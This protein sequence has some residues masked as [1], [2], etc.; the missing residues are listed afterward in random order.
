MKALIGITTNLEQRPGCRYHTLTERYVR[1][2]IR[3]GGLP[4]ILPSWSDP[5][6]PADYLD[7]IDGLLLTGGGDI[8]P[9]LY[10]E[11]PLAGLKSVSQ[12]R[13][14]AELALA[15]EALARG[16]PL[17]GVCRGHQ[18][19]NVAM[20]GSLYQDIATQL[21]GSSKH[22]AGEF[23]YEEPWHLIRLQGRGT[24]LF[25]IFGKESVGT[26]SFHHQAVKELAPG[27]RATATSADGVIEAMEAEEGSSFVLSVQFHP[28]GMIDGDPGFLGLFKAFVRA[29]SAG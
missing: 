18:V 23:P 16:M 6:S 13:D 19:L 1:S 5:S 27:L 10:G 20:G 25:E 2:V 21:P 24:R 12:R 29:A 3:A 8:A 26:N 28:E 14:Q 7:R 9:I 4:I 15:K 22:D 17:F 11:D